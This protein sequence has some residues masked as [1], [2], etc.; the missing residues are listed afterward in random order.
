MKKQ[1][2]KRRKRV[3]PAAPDTPHMYQHADGSVSQL[4]TPPTAPKAASSS[5]DSVSPAP[6]TASSYQEILETS[7]TS[8]TYTL[9]P[10]PVDFTNYRPAA[11]ATAPAPTT[12][13]PSARLKRTL[14]AGEEQA[15]PTR[16]ANS[17]SNL[18]NPTRDTAAYPITGNNIDPSLE[19]PLGQ[20]QQPG[21]SGR[22]DEKAAKRKKLEDERVA[23]EE[24]MRRLREEMSELEE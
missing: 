22:E 17:L 13:P 2:I 12:A 4:A 24:R 5:H 8:R 3:V 10:P 16:L 1:E 15:I 11:A 21:G 9:P 20:Q 19:G 6:T 18:L 7:E 23:L 14:E